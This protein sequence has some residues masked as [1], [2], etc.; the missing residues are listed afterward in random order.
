MTGR[1]KVLTE[2]NRL[3]KRTQADGVSA[4]ARFNTRRVFRFAF[5][6][7]HQDLIQESIRVTIQVVRNGRIGISSTNALDPDPLS[8]C[9]KRALAIAAH[10]PKSAE[11]RIPPSGGKLRDSKEWHAPT[12]GLQPDACVSAIQRLERLCQGSGARL[13]GSLLVGDTEQLLD[14]H[15]PDDRLHG[16]PDIEPHQPRRPLDQ[17]GQ[18]SAQIRA[19][20]LELVLTRGPALYPE[21]KVPRQ[22]SQPGAPQISGR[23]AE[24]LHQ[25]CNRTRAR[26]FTQRPC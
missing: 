19:M 18:Q 20:Q 10:T 3:V 2:L 1:T 23:Q 12:A 5:G 8:R 25:Y 11:D 24:A 26:H 9:V 17:D 15:R 16:S 13:A 21:A 6:A 7:I 14:R 22:L 4:I